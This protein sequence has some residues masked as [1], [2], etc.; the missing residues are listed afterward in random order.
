MPYSSQLRD[1]H[2]QGM[3]T[4]LPA[5]DVSHRDFVTESLGDN[6][7]KDIL[8][9]MD[10]SDLKIET[11]SVVGSN[12]PRHI[13]IEAQLSVSGVFANSSARDSVARRLL[14][15]GPLWVDAANRFC[16]GGPTRQLLRDLWTGRCAI[17]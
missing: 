14:R 2:L 15:R 17:C 7:I 4:F 6:P 1:S 11:A 10:N 5:G 16:R 13:R 12:L 3:V 9:R 8:L